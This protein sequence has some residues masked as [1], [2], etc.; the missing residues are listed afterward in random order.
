MIQGSGAP[1]WKGLVKAVEARALQECEQ[2]PTDFPDGGGGAGSVWSGWDRSKAL[3][4]PVTASTR[5]ATP[6]GSVGARS[7]ARR[8]WPPTEYTRSSTS[9]A[10]STW[11]VVPAAVTKARFSGTP[12]IWNPWAVSQDSTA[13]MSDAA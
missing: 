5:P 8:L 9:N 11:A 4:R 2:G 3:S 13:P 12:T 6:A 1:G 10:R 7:G